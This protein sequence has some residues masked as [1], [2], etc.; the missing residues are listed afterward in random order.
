MVSAIS[1]ASHSCYIANPLW[2][3]YATLPI[4]KPPLS[5]PVKTVLGPPVPPCLYANPPSVFLRLPMPPPRYGSLPERAPDVRPRSTTRRSCLFAQWDS[6]WNALKCVET[7][8]D[9]MISYAALSV[10]CSRLAHGA[11]SLITS[12]GTTEASSL[13]PLSAGQ[14]ATNEFYRELREILSSGASVGEL[15]KNEA[16]L[17]KWGC[18]A[19]LFN[20]LRRVGRNSATLKW[21]LTAEQQKSALERFSHDGMRKEERVKRKDLIDGIEADLFEQRGVNSGVAA[22]D[23]LGW[24][25]TL[26]SEVGLKDLDE[27]YEAAKMTAAASLKFNEA[28]LQVLRHWLEDRNNRLRG[29]PCCLRRFIGHKILSQLK[30]GL[31]TFQLLTSEPFISDNLEQFLHRFY[32]FRQEDF[33]WLDILRNAAIFSKADHGAKVSI[34]LQLSLRLPLCSSS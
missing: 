9:E 18:D 19:G 34:F 12:I 28:I 14:D 15:I 31:P 1:K 4:Y 10:E 30:Q 25:P 3:V 24:T 32:D 29:T 23:L 13:I 16:R 17:K 21:R 2:A 5:D 11:L 20:L 22:K 6:F 27:D 7:K 8:S 33:E 26:S